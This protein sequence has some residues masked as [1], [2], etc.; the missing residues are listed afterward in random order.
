MGSLV[1]EYVTSKLNPASRVEERQFLQKNITKAIQSSL[2]DGEVDGLW[3]SNLSVPRA[4]WT[5]S[6]NNL[7]ASLNFAGMEDREWRVATAHHETF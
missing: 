5:D 6:L 2:A 1:L 4:I 3:S 7:L